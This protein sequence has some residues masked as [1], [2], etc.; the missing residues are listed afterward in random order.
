MQHYHVTEDS[1]QHDFTVDRHNNITIV[2]NRHNTLTFSRNITDSGEV[3]SG[4]TRHLP[5]PGT[6]LVGGT[7]T[8]LTQTYTYTHTPTQIR[9]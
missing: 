4:S 1:N 6:I 7:K 2:L 3:T 9:A 5:G 8:H